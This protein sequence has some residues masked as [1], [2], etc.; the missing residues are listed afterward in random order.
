[1]TALTVDEL[2]DRVTAGVAWLDQHHPGWADRIDVDVLDL[3][4]SLSCVL[5]Q[6]VG[7]FWQTP[8]TYDQ[9]IGLGFEAAPGDLHAE[10]YAGLDGVWRA[11]IEER[12]GARRG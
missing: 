4:D 9:A 10:E 7:D 12:Q 11:V 6:V 2:Q 3:D 1:M 8:I 5:G